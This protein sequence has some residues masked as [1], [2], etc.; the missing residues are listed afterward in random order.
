MNGVTYLT[1]LSELDALDD[2]P[3]HG[4]IQPGFQKFIRNNNQARPGVPNQFSALAG[5]APQSSWQSSQSPQSSWQSSP[6]SS[7]QSSHGYSTLPQREH[8]R[9]S[10]RDVFRHVRRCDV[11]QGFYKRDNSFLHCVVVG[12]MA[13][14][15]LLLYQ[16]FRKKKKR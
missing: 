2:N 13:I 4:H 5:M 7:W 6:Q 3:P 10:C 11:C 16:L 14:I 9:L 15:F 1:D 8:A 12:Q